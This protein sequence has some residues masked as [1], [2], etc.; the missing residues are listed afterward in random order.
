MSKKESTRKFQMIQTASIRQIID[1]TGNYILIIV[2]NYI[3][4]FRLSQNLFFF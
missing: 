1:A 4:F 3:H 2:L